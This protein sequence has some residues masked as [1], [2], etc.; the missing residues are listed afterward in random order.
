MI[1]ALI[2]AAGQGTRAAGGEIPKQYAPIAGVPMLVRAARVFLDHPRIETLQI[3]IGPGDGP[4]FAPVAHELERRASS[5]SKVRRAVTGASSRQESVRLGLEA[6]GALAPDW[7]LIH[8]AARPFVSPDVIDRVID[9]LSAHPGAIAAEPVT[10]TLKRAT[11]SG[12]IA[13]TFDRRNLWRAQT[14]QGFHF[15][16]IRAAHRKAA[17][18]GRAFTD[19]AS[20]AEWA[21]VRVVLVQGSP[22]NVKITTAEDIAMA[23][24]AFDPEPRET[25]TGAGFDVHRFG[26]GDRVMLC[27][28]AVPHTHALEGHSD[29]DVGLHALTDALLG[30]IGGGDIGEH[31]PPSDPQWKGAPSAIFL[32]GAVRR[33]N[34]RGARIV[35]VDVTL[36][37][38]APRIAPHRTAMREAIARVLGIQIERV[39][40]KATTTEG[41]GFIGRHEGIAAMA[42]ATVTV[43]LEPQGAR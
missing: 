38:E 20:V 41:L 7:V 22:R 9:A 26:P 21:G 34:E 13:G 31:F 36:L 39:G 17:A 42:T 23:S 15:A 8:D 33:V 2:A 28:V 5:G 25:R 10:D 3:V 16:V 14:P 18:A 19:D 29:A 30:A 40:V 24:R 43:P 6:L 35:N 4:R 37:C 12:A 32:A 11:P 1:A 27:G